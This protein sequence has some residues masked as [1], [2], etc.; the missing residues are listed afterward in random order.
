MFPERNYHHWNVQ[1][2]WCK[3]SFFDGLK[4]GRKQGLS[5]E[6]LAKIATYFKVSVDF[7]LGVET[8][9]APTQEGEREI[10]DRKMKAAFLGG[11]QMAFPMKKLTGTGT[12]QETTLDIKS[13]RSARKPGPIDLYLFA[14]K[15]GIDVDWIPMRCAASLSAELP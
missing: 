15:N 12:M 6:T 5:A 11:L 4:K 8:K 1:R 13:S 7:L 10:D 3:Q 14:D 2:I 9:K